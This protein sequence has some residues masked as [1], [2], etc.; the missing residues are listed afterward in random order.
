MSETRT[1]PTSQPTDLPS[2]ELISNGQSIP[3]S[4]PI[5]SI[6]VSKEFNKI[7]SARIIIQDG[8]SSAEDFTISN[9][10][11]FTPGNGIEIKAG[12]HQENETIFKGLVTSHRIKIQNH[13]PSVIIIDCKD[14][15]YQMTLAPKNGY[16][17]ESTD[18]EIIEELAG[19]YNI[20]TDLS[21]TSVSH[22]QMVQY[23]CTDW[24]FCVMRAEAN[25]MVL[26]PDDGNLKMVTPNAEGE[27]TLELLFGATILEFDG[28]IDARPHNSVYESK[29]W[30]YASQEILE[31]ENQFNQEP[32]TGT[33]TTDDLAG[34]H[35][36]N[37]MLNQT[38]GL[39]KQEEMQA[40]ADAH[41]LKDKFS[42]LVG[43]VQHLGFP[44]IRPGDLVQLG[45]LGDRMNGKTVVSGVRHD[46]HD[47]T[48]TI[49]LFCQRF[50]TT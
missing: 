34:L 21:S 33:Q 10:D 37:E 20:Q 13:K 8:D 4:I 3:L 22:E 14:V 18:S 31:V 19:K 1:I 35:A 11:Y 48:F 28:E 49:S 50:Q 15:A 46:I 6:S 44:P 2:M 17:F 42:K 16:Y 27:A 25:G 40:W 7:S 23:Y 32:E 29:S 39:K 38:P 43:R 12:Y 45:G 36:D 30:D 24:D 9:E 47:G 26:L 5:L 41:A